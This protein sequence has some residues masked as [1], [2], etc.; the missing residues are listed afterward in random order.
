MQGKQK[1]MQMG[2]VLLAVVIVALS[3][4]PTS[5]QQ[6][7]LERIRKHYQLDRTN[8]KC[9]LCHEEKPKEEP[10]RKNLNSFG[11]MIQADPDMKP[12]LDKDEKYAFSTKELDTME[13]V[14]VKHESEDTDGD[15]VSNREEM[16]LGTYPGDAKSV[17]AKAALEKY[18]KDHPPAKKDDKK[19]A[20]K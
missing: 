11:K 17:P 13:A 6:K 1:F 5:A 7:F 9:T 3:I 14:V 10:G 12:L 18:R 2:A 20:K 8:G 19:D 16:D 4:G 15:G